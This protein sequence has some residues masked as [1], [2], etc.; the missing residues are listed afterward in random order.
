MEVTTDVTILDRL[1][2]ASKVKNDS[3][4]SRILGL[5]SQ[6]VSKARTNHKIPTAWIPKIALQFNVSTDWLFFGRGPM[7]PDEQ[8]EQQMPS[9]PITLPPSHQSVISQQIQT[10]PVLGLAACGISGWYNKDPIALRAPIPG[11]Y[12][13]KGDLIAVIA[14]G[15]SMQPDGIRQGYVVFCD[16]GVGIEQGDAVF[17]VRNDGS[18]S[19]KKY[20]KRDNTWLYL[21]GWLDPNENGEQ[22]QYIE[23]VLLK[24][25]EKIVAVVLV[26]RKA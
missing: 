26:Q 6:A 7:H 5:S 13:A 9:V 23:K 12:I 10:V 15:T 4:L 16:T 14:I 1:L 8:R 25:I 19:I 2:V 22:K 18:A 20:I 11:G 3:E 21:Q 24:L 17:I